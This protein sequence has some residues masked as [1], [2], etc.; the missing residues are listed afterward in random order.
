MRLKSSSVTDTN[1]NRPCSNLVISDLCS[2]ELYVYRVNKE[3]KIA[4][5]T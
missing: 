5:L 4:N 1:F 2:L 3:R